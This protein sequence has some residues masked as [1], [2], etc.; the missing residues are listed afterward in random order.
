M[1]SL[2]IFTLVGVGAQLVDGALGMAFGV[3]RRDGQNGSSA[4]RAEGAVRNRRSATR[5]SPLLIMSF[6]YFTESH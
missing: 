2:L 4:Q 1:H 6:R 5:L 3:T